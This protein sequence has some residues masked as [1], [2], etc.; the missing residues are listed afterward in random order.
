M[1]WIDL[2]LND[3]SFNFPQTSDELSE[4]ILDSQYPMV[5]VAHR[6]RAKFWLSRRWDL[7]E[8]HCKVL[9]PSPS[10]LVIEC[11]DWFDKER[12]TVIP[13]PKELRGQYEK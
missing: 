1:P 8:K 4:F 3:K 6:G 13:M 11:P 10:G 7:M 2:S 9:Y 5:E 12:R